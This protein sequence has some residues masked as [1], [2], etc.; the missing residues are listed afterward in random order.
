MVALT[1][2]KD[3][4]AEISTEATACPKCGRPLQRS[5]PRCGERTVEKVDGLKGSENLVGLLLLAFFLIPGL[6]YYFDR[7]RLPYCTTCKRRVPKAAS[8]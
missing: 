3:C 8:V 2:C 1:A 6:A 4:A 7:T 5:C